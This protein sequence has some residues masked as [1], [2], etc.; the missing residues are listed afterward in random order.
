MF[1]L[2]FIF[3]LIIS[4]AYSGT[5]VD[6]FDDRG[7]ALSTFP[8][9]Q[10]EIANKNQVR[11]WKTKG[12]LIQCIQFS[13]G[14]VG[15]LWFSWNKRQQYR[16]KIS[17][18]R[19]S[20]C[21]FPLE[22]YNTLASQYNRYRE[23]YFGIQ[24][25]QVVMESLNQVEIGG[26]VWRVEKTAKEYLKHHPLPFYNIE[27]NRVLTYR[28]GMGF[29][30]ELFKE[31]INSDPRNNMTRKS[32]ID[33]YVNQVESTGNQNEEN[34]SEYK[35]VIALGLG[36]SNDPKYLEDLPYYVHMF[37]DD[38]KSLGV[39]L[40]YVPVDPYGT[41][42]ENTQVIE[43]YL[44]DHIHDSQKIILMSLSK[45]APELI[46]ALGRLNKAGLINEDSSLK[47]YMNISGM[48]SGANIAYL[49]K[50]APKWLLKIFGM[51]DLKE[52]FLF[53]KPEIMQEFVAPY[54]HE[55]PNTLK[56]INLTGIL[57]G[58]GLIKKDDMAM[59]D[60]ILLNKT[61]KLFKGANDGLVEYP[62]TIIPNAWT[63]NTYTIVME[64]SHMILDGFI[65]NPKTLKSYDLF[66]DQYRKNV[67]KALFMTTLDL[68]EDRE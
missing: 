37:L 4:D 18:Y 51:S 15:G 59:T 56:Y 1:R 17:I 58:D 8:E 6:Y 2:F 55:L 61:L 43:K 9:Y 28:Y 35:I 22:K 30:S 68:I 5:I 21:R 52:P 23:T 45:G 7:A 57:P 34:Y 63:E 14:N 42:F 33:N 40:E 50:Y 12:G 19:V 24:L 36:W 27:T 41:T 20:S 66:E 26:N 25:P 47:A 13:D 46:R 31:Y 60:A 67:Y 53:I 3:L 44:K 48:I 38:M 32:F 11:F 16:R 62:G 65:T 29:A 64:S 39:D 54:A 10:I 49:E